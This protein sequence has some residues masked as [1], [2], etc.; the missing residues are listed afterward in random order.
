MDMEDIKYQVKNLALP[1]LLVF[2]AK[3]IM[4]SLHDIRKDFYDRDA[5][6]QTDSILAL[7]HS[8]K[9]LKKMKV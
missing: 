8:Y 6:R 1:D 3:Y 4:L 2:Y 7:D 5:M 9:V